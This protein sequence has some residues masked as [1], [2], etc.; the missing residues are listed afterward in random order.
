MDPSAPVQSISL[1]AWEWPAC[2]WGCTANDVV[3]TRAWL[4][5]ALG[6]ELQSCT[7]GQ[8]TSATI[9]VEFHSTTA[10][11]RYAVAM[12][13]EIWV[14]DTLVQNLDQ[15]VLD[16]VPGNGT[17][18]AA[19][20]TFDWNCG[21]KVEVRDLVLAWEPSAATCTG[22]APAC[23]DYPPAKCYMAETMVVHA[24]LVAS[25]GSTAPSCLGQSIAFTGSATGGESPYRYAWSFGDTSTSTL[26]NPTHTYTAPGA[27]TVTLTV[28]D[29]ATRTSSFTGTVAVNPPPV[30]SFTAA[31]TAGC[32]PLTAQFTNTSVPGTPGG[33]AIVGW[34]W[35]FGDGGSSTS[36]N[37]IHTFAS[38]GTYTVTLQTTDANGCV[39][40]FDMRYTVNPAVSV[41]IESTPSVCAGTAVLTATATGGNGSYTYA[42]DLD[43]DGQYD[44]AT[45]AT[46][47]VD[48]TLPGGLA[49][50]QATD[51]SGCTAT[52][53]ITVSLSAPVSVVLLQS[54]AD[55]CAGS[56]CFTAQASGGS[57]AYTYDWDLDNDGAYDDATS[58]AGSLCPIFATNGSHTVGV[59]VTDSNGCTAS[60]SSVVTVS[61]PAPQIATSKMVDQTSVFAGTEVQY[62]Y[63]VTNTSSCALLNVTL[64]DDKLG[65]IALSGLTDQ[66][67]DGSADDLAAGASASATA[68]ATINMDTTN[69]STA[70]GYNVQGTSASAQANAS[71]EVYNPSLAIDKRGDRTSAHIGDNIL[72]TIIVTN[73]GDVTLNG[74]S[75]VDAKLGISTNLGTLTAGASSVVTGTYEVT[76]ADLG[77]VVN[78]ATADSDETG[79][80]Q[81][82]W[83]VTVAAQP[84][85]SIEKVGSV[86]TAQIGD[87]VF[88]TITVRND[89]DV[90]LHNVTVVDAKLGINQNIGSLAVGA[91][92]TVQG[93]YLVTEADL[94]GIVNTATADSDETV[95]VQDTWTV[96]VVG[97]PSLTIVKSGP[98]SVAI[99]GT[100]DYVITVTN[101][102]NVTLSNVRVVD[103]KLGIDTNIGSLAPAASA[104]VYGSYGPVTEADL[105]IVHNVASATSDQ[106]TTPVEDDW[107]V[108][109]V[110]GPAL[111]IDKIGSTEVQIGGTIYYTVTVHNIGNINLHNV[112][113]LDAKIGLDQVI[114][115]LAV[116]GSATFYGAYGP[117]TPADMPVVQNVA[118]ATSLETPD[119]VQDEWNVYPS[120]I[121]PEPTPECIRTDVSVVI[122]GGWNGI[123]VN[124]W[125]G[126]GDQPIL[127]ASPNSFGEQQVT[128]TFY[129]PSNGSWKATVQPQMPGGLEGQWEYRLLRIESPTEGFVRQNPGSTEVTL[130]RC[131]Q[132]VYYY[133]LIN[134]IENPTPAPTGVPTPPTLPATG[135]HADGHV[136]EIA[137]I[138]IAALVLAWKAFRTLSAPKRVSPK[139]VS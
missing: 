127:Y 77:G 11:S 43:G 15:C 73:T 126:G 87:T 93:S 92:S 60:D 99:G 37:P 132:Y 116:D 122:Y 112:H 80:V 86:S 48:H 44:D 135:S 105:P 71:V 39:D 70:T 137:W 111:A 83:T 129:P 72:Y 47:Q 78:T 125:V 130:R 100:I 97:Q 64:D 139:R 42:W 67:S 53:S 121:Q 6:N 14:G 108:Q 56:V 51:S 110:T 52:R 76:E 36:Q 119:P 9:W 33:G 95:P 84:A 62:T 91:S 12:L 25:F 136:L 65:A 28:T 124:A 17:T 107:D 45:G 88:Y 41:S 49:K 115:E 2:N 46:V 69:T 1:T 13:G 34:Q 94:G 96:T 59:R 57:S 134:V 61:V 114:G 117:V 101:N 50:V 104:N 27:Y 98:A 90:S 4:G 113:V 54:T 131:N 106:T 35:S 85:L 109:I 66:D 10:Q 5:D 82:T 138:V 8:P 123:P 22:F 68:N 24:P 23:N 120:L 133:Q 3:A 19:V 32:A 21:A 63:T 89:G 26:Q 79:S 38:A 55:T 40:S 75:L 81:D 16:Y 118:T 29:V 18:Q 103:A 20:Y 102:G 128:W 30:A 58:A 74:V 7:P 31:P